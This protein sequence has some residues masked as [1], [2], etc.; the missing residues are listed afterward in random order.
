M[1]ACLVASAFS[2]CL[3]CGAR[4]PV[5]PVDPGSPAD[6]GLPA[7][8][9]AGL[10]AAQDAGFDGGAPSAEDAGTPLPAGVIALPPEPLR[11]GDPL[12]GYDALVNEGYINMGVP[13]S[14]FERAMTPLQARDTLPGR[15]GKNALVGY[16]LNVAKNSR[17]IEVAASNCLACHAWHL[18]GQLIVGL[19]RPTHGVVIPSG[20]ASNPTLISLGLRTP[21]EVAE[22]QAYG[23]RLFT[24]QEAGALFTFGALAAHRDPA[25]LTWSR[26]T[27]FD[28]SSSLQGWVDV[29]P[30]WRLKKKNALYANGMGR[31]DP[32]R[33]LMNMIVF[34]VED[35]AEAK[36]IESYFVD[37]AAFLRSLTP[38]VFP[39]AI[40]P[41]LAGAG[42]AVFVR[43]CSR[44]HGTY[45]PDGRYPNLLIPVE[46]VGTDPELAE[47]PWANAPAVNWFNTSFFGEV[48]RMEPSRG[49]MAPP[50]DGIWATAPFFHNGS[51]PTLEA[52]LDSSKRPAQWPMGFGDNDYDLIAVGWRAGTSAASYDTTLTGNSNRGHVFAD[53]LSTEDRRALLEYLKT[54]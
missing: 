44:C 53:G 14:G 25:T 40:D 11:P 15:R 32:V 23:E 28:A 38:P 13:W 50:L 51:V 31:G 36:R 3:A 22:Y 27:R 6:A 45:G 21:A 34:S 29:P 10:P 37:V 26:T 18:N 47:H 42:E 24:S 43:T 30:W 54:L 52:V 35:T 19:G 5:P 46:Q 7:A 12:R 20:V 4:P 1:R 17:G 41:V 33:H 2:L 9:D 39:S 48:S 16:S 8:D 49:Y